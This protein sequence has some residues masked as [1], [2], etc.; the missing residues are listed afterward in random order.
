MKTNK[1][2]EECLPI[3]IELMGVCGQNLAMTKR[4]KDLNILF[5]FPIE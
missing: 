3:K 1:L 2:A 5:Q 4:I